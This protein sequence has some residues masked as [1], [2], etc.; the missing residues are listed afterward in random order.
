MKT[1]LKL[2]LCLGLFAFATPAFS[3]VP[4]PTGIDYC[5]CLEGVQSQA[6]ECPCD[7]G[8][9]NTG[10]TTTTTTTTTTGTPT[11]TGSTPSGGFPTGNFPNVIAWIECWFDPDC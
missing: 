4:D 5:D 8:T 1:F 3:Q 10:G 7:P 9:H 2:S 6:D 11:E